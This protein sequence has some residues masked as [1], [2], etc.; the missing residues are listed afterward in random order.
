VVNITS[1]K[2]VVVFDNL[3]GGFCLCVET[4]CL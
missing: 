1:E 3:L 2:Y 4:H